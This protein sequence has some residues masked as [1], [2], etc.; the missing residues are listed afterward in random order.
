MTGTGVAGVDQFGQNLVMYGN[1]VVV[2]APYR[3]N[4][5]GAV[6]V[7]TKGAKGW[8]QA[9]E[10]YGAGTR[11]GDDFGWVVAMDGNTFVAGDAT[12]AV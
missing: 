6:Y 5:Q 3:N 7:F 10:I 11:T 9:A 1:T 12:V 8:A 2:N 4:G